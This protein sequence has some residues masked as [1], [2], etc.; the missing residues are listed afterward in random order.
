MN[1]YRGAEE[2]G[3]TLLEIL[4]VVTIIAA[5]ASIAIPHYVDYRKEAEE[6]VCLSNRRNI[7]MEETGY[8]LQHQ[9]PSL[10]IADSYKCPS[11]GTYAWLVSEPDED[12]YPRVGCSIHFMGSDGLPDP[13]PEPPGGTTDPEP[14]A[15][16][17]TTDPEPETPTGTTDLEPETPAVTP[18]LAMDDLTEYILSLGLKNRTEDKLIRWLEKALADFEKGKIDKADKSLGSF[19]KEVDKKSKEIDDE[20]ESVLK[21]KASEIQEMLKPLL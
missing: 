11:G 17:G 5:L 16:T 6:A 8:F 9:V 20:A 3:F 15:P 4:V 2:D 18:D 21:Q 13:V 19:Q 7:E 12:G 14:E 10:S 1:P